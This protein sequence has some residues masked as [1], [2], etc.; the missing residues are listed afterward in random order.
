MLEVPSIKKKSMLVVTIQRPY[1]P[2]LMDRIA[3]ELDSLV[4]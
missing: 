2:G 4:A 1:D 3:E